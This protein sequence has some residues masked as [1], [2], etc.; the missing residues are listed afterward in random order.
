MIVLLI[1]G[2]RP[3]AIKLAPVIRELRTHPGTKPVVCVTAQ[4]RQMLDQVLSLFKIQPDYD[5]NV[6]QVNQ[7]LFDITGQ[8]LSK[9]EMVLR[10]ERPDLVLVQGDTTTAFVGAL[11]SF[12][13]KIP[14]GHVEAGLRTYNKYSPFPEEMNRVLIDHLADLCFVPTEKAQQNLLREGVTKDRI[15]VTGNSVVDA[16]LWVMQ[17]LPSPIPPELESLL[18][19][20]SKL[21]NHRLILVTGHRRESF[22]EGLENI[23]RALCEI[24]KGN[25]DVEIVYS[26]HLNPNVREPVFRILS[27]VPRIHLIEPLGYLPFV[28]LMRLAYLIL[29][30]SGGIQEEVPT[31]GKPVLVMRNV[32]ERPE[33]IEAGA[34]KLVGTDVASIVDSTQQLLDDKHEYEQMARVVNPYG[35]G[36]AAKRIVDIILGWMG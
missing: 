17:R 1:F 33:G 16:L 25:N 23:C 29:T 27:N 32:T 34:A 2:T 28:Q 24:V 20:G 8:G 14:V 5:L 15:F 10:N 3:E 12:Y 13:Q 26:V 22:G 11:A 36:K 18:G 21:S 6:M 31:L 7:S 9:I 4:H 35:D 19:R 30:D